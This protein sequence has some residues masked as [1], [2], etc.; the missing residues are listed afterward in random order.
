MR[1]QELQLGE[2]LSLKRM[3]P[4]AWSTYSRF[5]LSVG[6]GSAAAMSALG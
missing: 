2:A 1:T 6:P 3:L 4:W 5:A